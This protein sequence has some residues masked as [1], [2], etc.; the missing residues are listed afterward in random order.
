[1]DIKLQPVNSSDGSAFYFASLP[2]KITWS[3]DTKM[4]SFDIISLGTV[5]VPK[6]VSPQEVSWTGEFFGSQKKNESG[7]VKSKYW[8]EPTK[9]MT[10]LKTWRDSGVVLNLVISGTGINLDVTISSIEAEAYGAFG[11]IKYTIELLQKRE[12]KIYTTTELNIATYV[13]KTKKRTTTKKTSSSGTKYTIV[14]GDTLWGIAKK[15][16]GSGTK[17]TKIYS[18]NK[19]TI[20]AAAKKHGRSSS[21]KGHWIYPG[22]VLTIPAS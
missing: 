9:C 12:L 10:Q 19:S 6:G 17:W 22:T 7:I 16:L 5:K 4:Q 3:G 14:S 21:S 15:K 8:Q 11:N 18:A 1:M 20:E 2:E 13:K